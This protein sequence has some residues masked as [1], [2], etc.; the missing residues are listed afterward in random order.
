M[1]LLEIC[2]AVPLPAAQRRLE[3]FFHQHFTRSILHM[4]MRSI[5]AMTSPVA[6]R[7]LN[8]PSAPA[9]RMEK[10]CD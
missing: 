4:L 2:Q 7:L 5:S 3:S 1:L 6:W 8:A 10:T 9:R